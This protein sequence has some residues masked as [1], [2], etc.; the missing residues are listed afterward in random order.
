MIVY[1]LFE[2]I[3]VLSSPRMKAISFFEVNPSINDIICSELKVSCIRIN[4]NDSIANNNYK[5]IEVHF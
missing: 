4:G 3:D 5:I 1:P 2:T